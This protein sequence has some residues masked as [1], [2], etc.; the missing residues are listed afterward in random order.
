MDV[1]CGK[2][3]FDQH[4]PHMRL[5]TWPW[6]SWPLL[7]GVALQEDL[8]RI[9]RWYQAR[10]Y[11]AARIVRTA[12]VPAQALRSDALRPRDPHPG[13]N[14]LRSGQGCAVDVAVRVVEGRPTLVESIRVRGLQALSATLRRQVRG[15]V[16][17]RR[18]ERFDEA[19][20]DDSK[21]AIVEL[22]GE[23]GRARAT[24]TGTVRI[25]RGRRRASIELVVVPGPSARFGAVQVAGDGGRW[26]SLIRRTAAIRRGAVYR[27]SDLLDAQLAV[28]ALGGFSIVF[29]DPVL[30]D[31]D[32]P[33]NAP[34]DVRI[35]VVPLR[36]QRVRVGLGVQSGVIGAGQ[37]LE[38]TSVPEWDVHL[39]GRYIQ[40]DLFGG[41]RSLTI[42]ERPRLV[43]PDR[44]PGL[45]SPKLGNVVRAELR[46]PS[47]IEARTW[48]VLSTGHEYGPDPFD[49]FFRH[50]VDSGAA[51][52]RYLLA[53]QHLYL[54]LGLRNSL[55][56]VPG[57]QKTAAGDP[58]PS[59]SVATFWEERVRLDLRDVPARPHAGALVSLTVH[60]AGYGL[61]SSWSYVR[62]LPDARVYVPLPWQITLA[63]RVALGLLWVGQA[64]SDLD[65]LSQQLGPRDFRLRGGGA[66]SNRGFLAGSLGD[67]PEGGLRRWEASVEL[68]VPISES[69]GAVLFAD[70]GDV[71]RGTTFRLDHPQTSVGLGLR[72]FTL[73]GALCLDIG[74][75]VPGWQVLAE[76]D[77][78]APGAPETDVKIFS[79]R[80]PGAVHFSL[81]EAF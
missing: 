43:V 36:R 67:G 33:A 44:F 66:S 54:S 58:A 73:I 4:H 28:Y 40:R 21:R 52:E 16:T 39:F 74:W 60:E 25:D 47:L 71:H 50:R 15:A 2:P 6:A 77:R 8:H 7:D 75:R 29:V 10:G 9:E 1:A 18:G 13:C 34:I 49:E 5:W 79:W 17:L 59:S 78:R 27:R 46:Q 69:F 68:R 72:L 64:D 56:F 3:P 62:L 38:Q 76:T 35:R 57:G 48:G 45:V 26:T 31:D 55:S 51:L 53:G 41:L 14:R 63:A 61:P 70:A 23:H 65:A 22:L 81:G 19:T 80:F 12:V 42:D 32:A 24:V 11:H 37:G 30:P 20:Y